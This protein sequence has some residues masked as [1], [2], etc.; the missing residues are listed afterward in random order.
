M[1]KR[2]GQYG[3]FS[4]ICLLAE[5]HVASLNATDAAFCCT[6]KS[7]VDNVAVSLAILRNWLRLISRRTLKT[8]SKV[9]RLCGSASWT[10]TQKRRPGNNEAATARHERRQQRASQ[11][12]QATS[13]S[14]SRWSNK[15]ALFMELFPEIKNWNNLLLLPNVPAL[16]LSFV[17]F[18]TFSQSRSRYGQEE[19]Q[20]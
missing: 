13:S 16:S 7:I 19:G 18:P 15:I 14:A 10:A 8:R 9:H 2:Y 11:S 1:E 17:L 3:R 6:E 4:Q 12:K 20:S 5:R